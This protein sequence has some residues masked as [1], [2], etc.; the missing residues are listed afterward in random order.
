[1]WPHCGLQR[2]QC[3]CSK[4][5]NV[6]VTHAARAEGEGERGRVGEKGCPSVCRRG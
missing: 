5:G 2:G 4:S 6:A 3:S 1:M